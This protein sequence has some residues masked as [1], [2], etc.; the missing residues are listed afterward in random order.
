QYASDAFHRLAEIERGVH[1]DLRTALGDVVDKLYITYNNK[2]NTDEA[3]QLAWFGANMPSTQHYFID[4]YIQEFPSYVG[5]SLSQEQRQQVADVLASLYFPLDVKGYYREETGPFKGTV[6]S[7][8][9]KE[10]FLQKVATSDTDTHFVRIVGSPRWLG[11]NKAVLR[12]QVEVSRKGKVDFEALKTS[13]QEMFDV[14]LTSASNDTYDM[15]NSKYAKRDDLVIR[16]Y[17]RSGM[18]NSML[19]GSASGSYYVSPLT[20]CSRP[21]AFDPTKESIGLR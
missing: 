13:S 18:A 5:S 10:G 11:G 9:W 2:D 21:P 16:W 19:Y 6:W 12:L 14:E 7:V 17:P 4:K 20:P 3:R 15:N 1:T 8:N